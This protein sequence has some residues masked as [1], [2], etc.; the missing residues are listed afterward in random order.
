MVSQRR[1]S[2]SAEEARQLHRDALVIDTQQPPITSGIVFTPGMR[3]TL[4]ELAGQGRP[5]RVR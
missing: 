4:A 3:G 1:A 5:R 2:L